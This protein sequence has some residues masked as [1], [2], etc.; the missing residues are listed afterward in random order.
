MK[1]KIGLKIELNATE[2]KMLLVVLDHADK[3]TAEQIKVKHV[4]NAKALAK[5]IADALFTAT[6]D[7]HL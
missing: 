2:A 1:A 7:E 6:S 5:V 3:C 4:N